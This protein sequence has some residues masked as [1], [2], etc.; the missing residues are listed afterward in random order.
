MQIFRTTAAAE[1]REPEAEGRKAV[2]S[3][4]SFRGDIGRAAYASTAL[5]A[6]LLQHAFVYTVLLVWGLDPGTPWW[7]W[8]SP[9]RMFT[10][11]IGHVSDWLLLL[12]VFIVLLVTWASLA[13]AY[14]R[15]RT[16]G[17]GAGWTALAIIPGLQLALIAWLSLA[18]DSKFGAG[19]MQAGRADRTRA[20]ALGLLT[21]VA[22]CLAATVFATLVLGIYGYGLFLAS[23]F[24]IGM[25]VAYMA[26]RETPLG[27]GTTTALVLG[28]LGLGALAL[29]GVALEGAICILLAS[30]L[31]AFMGF[32]G[33][34][35]GRAIAKRRH[36]RRTVLTSLV[37]LPLL[38]SGEALIPPRA[39][40][41][42]VE[43]IEVAAA[44]YAVW[45]SV[46]HMGPIP[47]APAAPFRWGLAYPLRGEIHGSG[48]GA[49]RRGVFSTGVAYERVVEWV[50]EHRL[51]FIVLSDPPSMRELS[52]YAHVDAPHV[53]G[54]FRTRDAR[55]TI[56][57]LA[58]GR[59]RLT[60][61]T[62]HDLDLEP[63]LYWL[64][65]A[66]LAVHENKVRVL[67]HFRQQAEA[68][69]AAGP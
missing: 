50:P 36:D 18:P 13:L 69:T 8:L 58:D 37:L 10:G 24:V 12:A 28:A 42:S 56:T 11:R 2:I 60:L 22:L 45:D 48:V 64:P 3:P 44:P 67:R 35:A 17:A 38:L 21:G 66:R 49:I 29:M 68:I 6:F 43:S 27:L 31:I 4:F 1:A 20:L 57:P 62:H 63:A 59:T 54:Y 65:L 25:T 51:S 23:P 32:I 16:I 7:F 52:P 9:L 14:R 53:R 26:N 33:A 15:T 30:P 47:D 39:D 19:Q 40:F 34:I 46:V 5:V 61:A 41:E 55:F